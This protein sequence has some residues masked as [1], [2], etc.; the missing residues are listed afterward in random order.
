MKKGFTLIELLA[1]IV[2][3]AVI[4]LIATP[5]I[6]NVIERARKGAIQETVNGYIESI[7]NEVAIQM[8]ETDDVY[9]D[10]NCRLSQKTMICNN[11]KTIEVKTKGDQLD[12]LNITFIEKGI[13]ERGEF[14]KGKYC[15]TYRKEV[16]VKF[17]PCNLYKIDASEVSFT[18]T[19]ENW[20]VSS[21]EE[22]LDSLR[23]LKR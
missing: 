16:G 20:K 4:A 8:L 18:P 13:I 10:T 12:S 19:D 22:A 15:G 1:V 23:N 17:I 5:M 3:L 7:Q 11:E 6:M 9:H 14:R 21:V 2:I